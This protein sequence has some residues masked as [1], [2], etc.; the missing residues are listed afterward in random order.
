MPINDPARLENQMSQLHEQ[1]MTCELLY[2]LCMADTRMRAGV[3]RCAWEL[4]PEIEREM[5]EL[6]EDRYW[7]MDSEGWFSD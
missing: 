6:H 1:V 4:Y 5:D 3:S 2:I 7:E